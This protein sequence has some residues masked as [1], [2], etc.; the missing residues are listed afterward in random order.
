MVY[1]DST[2]IFH[3]RRWL[4]SRS[5]ADYVY[6]PFFKE[7]LT[8]QRRL[9]NK[10]RETSETLRG[11]DVDFVHIKGDIAVRVNFLHYKGFRDPWKCKS[12][13][14]DAKRA[15]LLVSSVA[16]THGPSTDSPTYS[17]LPSIGERLV[18]DLPLIL[19]GIAYQRGSFKQSLEVSILQ[20][21]RNNNADSCRKSYR[22]RQTTSF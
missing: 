8:R 13:H 19:L 22:R 10:V 11:A 16:Y 18:F 3:R 20:A 9:P 1:C 14:S 2:R 12:Q 6:M 17:F 15:V 4:P 7:I 5:L 21:T